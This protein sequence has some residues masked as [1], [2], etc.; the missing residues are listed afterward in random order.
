MLQF[1]F[2]TGMTSKFSPL[3]PAAILLFPTR[4]FFENSQ[5]GRRHAELDTGKSPALSSA[6]LKW[7]DKFTSYR[8]L[9]EEGPTLFCLGFFHNS[10]QRKKGSCQNCFILH[11]DALQ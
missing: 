6:T 5:K 9:L 10:F 2:A 7:M 3:N 11:F 1:Y 8:R 4:F